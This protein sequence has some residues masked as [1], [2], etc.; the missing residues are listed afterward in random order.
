MMEYIIGF[1][2]GAAAVGIITAAVCFRRNNR[3]RTKDLA[4]EQRTRRA[5]Q[6]AYAGTLA[7]RLIHEIK[8][9]LN[10]LSLRLQLL[11]EEHQGPQTQEQRRTLKHIETLEEETQRL[12]AILDDFMGFIRQHR[13]AL[14]DC[15]LSAI[16]QQVVDLL[17]PELESAGIEVRSSLAAIPQCRLD[18]ALIKQALVNLIL[19]AKQAVSGTDTR[20]IIL[21]TD[22]DDDH[23]RID[24]I[25]TG[26]GIPDDDKDKVFEA[27]FSTRKGGTGL[28]L[29]TTRKIIEEHGGQI[30]LHSDRGRGSCFTIQLPL[31]T[32]R[33]RPENVNESQEDEGKQ[34]SER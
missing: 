7:G 3:Q 13:L 11:A 5:E 21:R 33:T 18:T 24:V 32:P 17:R 34:P 31:A 22:H 9:P 29:P 15:D 10:T 8:N 4:A 19:N 2:I 27:F 20:E 1:L 25:D 23:A 30:L 16:V 26:R 14:T 12:A 6:L 28:G